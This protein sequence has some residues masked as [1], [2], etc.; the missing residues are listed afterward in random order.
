MLWVLLVALLVVPWIEFWL[1]MQLHWPTWFTI[2][3]CLGAA[4]VGW[5]FARGED[6]TLWTEMESAIQNKQVPTEEAVDAMLVQI[7]AWALILPGLLSDAAGIL[8]LIPQVREALVPPIRSYIR[9]HW[10]ERL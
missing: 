2:A 1:V 9:L 8:L 3:W 7:G 4:A 10:V 6:L 5:W